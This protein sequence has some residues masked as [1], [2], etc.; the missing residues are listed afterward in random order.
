MLHVTIASAESGTEPRTRIA[1]ALL[2]S[3]VVGVLFGP[4]DLAGQVLLPAPWYELANSAAVWAAAAFVLGRAIRTG[5]KHAAAC[6]AVFLT[7]AVESYYLAAVIS[8]SDST[9]NLSSPST[10]RWLVLG[11]LAGTLFGAAGAWTRDA[12]DLAA[13]GAAAFGASVLFADA[14]VLRHGWG[15]VVLEAALGAIVLFVTTATWRRRWMALVASVPL[16]AL[17]LAGFAAAGFS[18]G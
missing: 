13:A 8:L 10:V 18:I 9:A 2:S 12:R 15:A 1:G 6:G 4:L 7:V 17:A 5:W 14:L 11:V 3:A 16:I